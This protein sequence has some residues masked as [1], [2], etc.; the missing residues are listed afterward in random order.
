M[1]QP[2]YKRAKIRSANVPPWYKHD[3]NPTHPYRIRTT[4]V[5]TRYGFRAVYECKATRGAPAAISSPKRG[6][7]GT[8][9][10]GR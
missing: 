10:T 5:Q 7:S 8:G 6:V 2:R 9:Q 4:V 3:T 1:V